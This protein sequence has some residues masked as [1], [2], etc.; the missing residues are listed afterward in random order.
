M[1]ICL[2]MCLCVLG[3]HAGQNMVFDFLEWELQLAM[4]YCVGAGN[5]TQVHST[6]QC[7]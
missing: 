5:Q 6:S 3:V 2:H 7:S 1:D 4:S